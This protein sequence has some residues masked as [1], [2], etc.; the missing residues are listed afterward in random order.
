MRTGDRSG[1]YSAT[2]LALAVM[3]FL[4]C[5]AVLAFIRVG[6]LTREPFRGEAPV[7]GRP[8][9]AAVKRIEE[10]AEKRVE[11]AAPPA[12]L[13]AP[14]APVPPPAGAVGRP[15]AK[16]PPRSSVASVARREEK[17]APA[18]AV[19]PASKPVEKPAAAAPAGTKPAGTKV[20]IEKIKP[21]RVD[22]NVAWYSVRVGFSDSGIRTDT[23]RDVLVKQGFPK[24][25]TER[26]GDGLYYVVVSE[27]YF[28]HL[29]EN[30]VRLLEEMGF[31]PVLH[32][33]TV[34]R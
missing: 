10:P 8:P 20:V 33:R 32:E 29:A 24:A 11:P 9:A 13:P 18:P 3:A 17:P 12:P 25:K 7:A 23:L 31:S 30:D 21:G 4:C 16:E 6:G 22:E 28:R 27:Y 26:G 34:A 5:A 14:R 1:G 2:G 19:T 15:A